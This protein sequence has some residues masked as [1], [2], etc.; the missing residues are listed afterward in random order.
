MAYV[1]GPLESVQLGPDDVVVSCHACGSLSDRVLDM[2]LSVRAKVVILPCCQNVGKLDTG[3]LEGWMD[4]ALAVDVVRANRLRT[5]GYR[6]RTQ[7]IPEEISPKNRLLLG[8][9]K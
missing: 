2:A 1:E 5:Q 7:K 3:H 6:I 4:G 8:E 9:P